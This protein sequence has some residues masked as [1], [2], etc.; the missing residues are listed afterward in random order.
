MTTWLNLVMIACGGA[1]GAVCR[2]GITMAAVAFPGGSTLWGTTVANVLGCGLL[3]AL[4]EYSLIEGNLSPKFALACRVGFLGSL[5][6]FST[7]T[8]ESVTS[9]VDGRPAVTMTYVAANLL[10]GVI[11]LFSAAAV[12]RHYCG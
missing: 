1:A 3:G 5:T 9:W 12:V 10:L 8:A 6:T 7:F 11:A 4:A 2:Y